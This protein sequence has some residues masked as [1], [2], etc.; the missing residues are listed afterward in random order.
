MNETYLDE[1]SEF[2][3]EKLKKPENVAGIIFVKSCEY[4]DTSLPCENRLDFY[5]K[6][7]A[8]PFL[9][10]ERIKNPIVIKDDKDDQTKTI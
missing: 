1:G 9:C 8:L 2:R 6:T 4:V 10:L 7:I 5:K 3:L